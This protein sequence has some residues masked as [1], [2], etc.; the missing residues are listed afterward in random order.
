MKEKKK[1][2]PPPPPQKKTSRAF[3]AII[4]FL[5]LL[6]VQLLDADCVHESEECCKE[7]ENR[8]N[9]WHKIPVVSKMICYIVA[10]RLRIDFARDCDGVLQVS[11]LCHDE[12]IH[13]P[14]Q[15]ANPVVPDPP[16]GNFLK[17]E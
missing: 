6:E 17:Q 15:W 16:S 12:P 8:R 2:S 3:A 11:V 14:C 1:C 7:H 4:L 5:S 9:D 10:N 13:C